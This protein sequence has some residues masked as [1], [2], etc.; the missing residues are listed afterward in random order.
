MEALFRFELD[1]DRIFIFN[2][3]KKLA[4]SVV[5]VPASEPFRYLFEADP[6]SPRPE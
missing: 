5:G 1:G 6:P 3:G 2:K 4:A